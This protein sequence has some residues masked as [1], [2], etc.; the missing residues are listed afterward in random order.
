MVKKIII[1][2]LITINIYSSNIFDQKCVPCHKE[3]PTSLQQMFMQYL[4]LYSSEKNVKYILK[5]YLKHP[6]KELS[7]MSDLFIDVY[8]IK[9]PSKLSDE[10]LKKAIDIYWD[11]YKVI[12]NLK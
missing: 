10:E 6:S 2:A 7:A 8:G 9:E 3:L 1:Y 4:Q 5:Y 11:R 12:G